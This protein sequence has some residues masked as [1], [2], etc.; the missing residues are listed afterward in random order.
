MSHP[1]FLLTVRVLVSFFPLLVISTVAARITKIVIDKTES[2]TFAGQEFAT[3]G[4]YEKLTGRVFGEIDPNTP[5]NAQIVNLDKAPK[6]A[7][8]RVNYSADI[9]ILK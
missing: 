1:L 5:G 4:P 2:P 3:V 9:Y 8:G 7:A 6:R